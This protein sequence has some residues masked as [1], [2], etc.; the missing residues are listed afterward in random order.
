MVAGDPA[1]DFRTLNYETDV[2][3]AEASISLSGSLWRTILIFARSRS[4]AAR[5]FSITAL[6]SR[7]LHP[8]IQSDTTTVSSSTSGTFVMSTSSIG[9]T[10]CRGWAIVVAA[11]GPRTNST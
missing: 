2:A 6:V 8:R 1:W 10:W 9:S 5:S 3:K 11:P 4:V 7:R